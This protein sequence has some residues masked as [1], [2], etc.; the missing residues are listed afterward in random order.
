MLYL[1]LDITKENLKMKKVPKTLYIDVDLY[2]GLKL[3]SED[4]RLT[5]SAMIRVAI[6]EYLDNHHQNKQG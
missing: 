2:D 4:T 3:I 6:K 1:L 5:P